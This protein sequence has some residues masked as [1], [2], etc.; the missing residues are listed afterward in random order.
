MRFLGQAMAGGLVP[1]RHLPAR[2][3]QWQAGSGEVGGRGVK[4]GQGYLYSDGIYWVLYLFWLNLD[5]GLP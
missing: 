2:A 3:S 4:R 1:A 5:K